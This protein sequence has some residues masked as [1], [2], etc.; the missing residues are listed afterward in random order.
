MF[1]SIQLHLVSVMLKQ[2]S[3]FRQKLYKLRE[4]LF[5]KKYN[6]KNGG[7]TNWAQLIDDNEVYALVVE[8]SVNVSKMKFEE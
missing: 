3:S 7:Y 8:G 4:N 5:L 2:E 6:K 1:L